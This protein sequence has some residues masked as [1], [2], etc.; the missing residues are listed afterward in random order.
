MRNSSDERTHDLDA[1]MRIR[2]V[3]ED[4]AHAVVVREAMRFSDIWVQSELPYRN[5]IR[6][7]VHFSRTFSLAQKSWISG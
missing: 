7:A 5:C 1:L 6:F 4:I 3:P 2:V